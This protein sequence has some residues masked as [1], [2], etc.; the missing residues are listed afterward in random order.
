MN[1]GSTWQQVMRYQEIYFPLTPALSPGRGGNTGG[2][3]IVRYQKIYFPLTPAL[4][5]GRGGNN[6]WSAGRGVTMVGCKQRWIIL[7]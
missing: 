2:L 7:I 4:S 6:W 3:Q 1:Q 5:P